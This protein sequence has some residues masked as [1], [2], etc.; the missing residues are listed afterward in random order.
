MRKG[1]RKL[2]QWHR[3]VLP[4]YNQVEWRSS[5]GVAGE[6]VVWLNGRPRDECPEW[7]AAHAGALW[8]AKPPW[9]TQWA[10]C[11][12]EAKRYCEDEEAKIRRER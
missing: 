7:A 1:T 9:L 5:G 4:S 2:L 3:V 8:F 6:Y 11:L 12:A 10:G